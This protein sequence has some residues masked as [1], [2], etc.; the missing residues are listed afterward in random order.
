L[1][2]NSQEF[3]IIKYVGQEAETAIDAQVD[4]SSSWR[5]WWLPSVVVDL[6]WSRGISGGR[7]LLKFSHTWQGFTGPDVLS[8]GRDSMIYDLN[9]AETR[10]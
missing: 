4:S 7:D 5:E 2:V 3:P 9:P 6:R 8:I 10:F 1:T